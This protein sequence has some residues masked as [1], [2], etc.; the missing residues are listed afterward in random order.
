[1]WLAESQLIMPVIWIIFFVAI[2][3]V[4]DKARLRNAAKKERE[5]EQI[6]QE[7]A[8]LR[9]R[10]DKQYADL[11]LMLED[12]LRARELET[13]RQPD[14]EQTAEKMRERTDDDN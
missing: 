2:M 1:M 6:R 3:I 14:T 12:A 13:L 11:T 7:M 8:A 9:E 10:M 4:N 5:L